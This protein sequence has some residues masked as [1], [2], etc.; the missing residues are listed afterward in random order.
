MAFVA[1]LIIEGIAF[2][3]FKN[4]AQANG[5]NFSVLKAQI[6]AEKAQDKSFADQ[7]LIDYQVYQA[8]R[9]TLFDLGFAAL[10]N[11]LVGQ[12]TATGWVYKSA[13]GSQDTS[14]LSEERLL[15][16]VQL[17]AP[18]AQIVSIRVSPELGY[19]RFDLRKVD[20]LSGSA[21]AGWA[22]RE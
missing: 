12:R 19:L 4:K 13:L 17:A 9:G 18:S 2:G 16:G 7:Q 11:S 15:S 21:K 22:N 5:V 8:L 6:D 3:A 1:I 10:A 20:P 14:G